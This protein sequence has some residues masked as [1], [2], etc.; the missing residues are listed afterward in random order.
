MFH[1]V[2]EVSEGQ[3]GDGVH[4]ALDGKDQADLPVGQPL[5]MGM[6][7]QV[8]DED[9]Q[10]EAAPGG[11]QPGAQQRQVFAHFPD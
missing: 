10:A 2:A 6:Q 7:G 3:A 4:Q 9:A 1:P 11:G 5:L 8:G